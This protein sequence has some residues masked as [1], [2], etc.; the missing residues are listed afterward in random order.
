MLKLS[1]EDW[2]YFKMI[3]KNKMSTE[4]CEQILKIKYLK[5]KHLKWYYNSLKALGIS[6]FENIKLNF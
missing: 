1:A 6:K 3:L 2:I 4:D 5:Y